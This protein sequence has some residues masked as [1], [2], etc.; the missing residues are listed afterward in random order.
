MT[1][2]ELVTELRSVFADVPRPGLPKNYVPNGKL[3]NPGWDEFTYHSALVLAEQL[4]DHV[5][6][7]IDS[8]MDQ[9]PE[10]LWHL[11]DTERLGVFS[12]RQRE[13]L[14]GA[15]DF[16]QTGC[17]QAL[18]RQKVKASMATVRRNLEGLIERGQ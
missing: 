17:K 11:S 3:G 6:R 14:L 1:A 15:L 18:R 2:D 10:L 16:L 12:A 8:P 7:A 5:Q 9:L 4:P 13:V